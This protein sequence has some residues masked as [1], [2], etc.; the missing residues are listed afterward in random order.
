M[1]MQKL[2]SVLL[3]AILFSAPAFA[4]KFEANVDPAL[5]QQMT[6]DLN[7]IGQVQGPQATPLHQKVFGALNGP[8]YAKWFDSRIVSIGKNA[9]GG[10]KAVACVIPMLGSNRMWATPKSR[11][12]TG[13]TPPAR[14]L[15]RTL[16]V[17]M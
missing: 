17:T 11:M 2:L 5:R 12:G 9:C 3:S 13:A 6:D 4:V 16:M 10:G 7:F 14:L 8:N 15:S 1:T